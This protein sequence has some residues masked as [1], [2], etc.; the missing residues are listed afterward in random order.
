MVEVFKTDVD[1]HKD[2]SMLVAIIQKTFVDYKV[3][4]DLDDC[5]RILRVQST[6]AVHV[7]QVLDILRDFGFYI[8]VLN[9][10][11]LSTADNMHQTSP[12]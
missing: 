10:V 5:D 6:K 4:F 1:D 11:E 9:E 7:S 12:L 8:E 2:A 3:N